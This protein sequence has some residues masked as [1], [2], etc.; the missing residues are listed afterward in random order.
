MR[1]IQYE[2]EITTGTSAR[3]HAGDKAARRR[4][5][6]RQGYLRINGKGIRGPISAAVSIAVVWIY[7]FDAMA[8]MFQEEQ[9]SWMGYLIT[10][11]IVAGGSKGSIK[12]FQDFLGWKSDATKEYEEKKKK[13]AAEE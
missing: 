1:E 12:L 3:S 2:S 5:I 8:I 9:A 4:D 11:S 13:A 6:D 7:G 10:G